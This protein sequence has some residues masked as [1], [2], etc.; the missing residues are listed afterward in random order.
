MK[1]FF[2]MEFTGLHQCTSPISLGLV[3]ESGEEF[4][5]EFTDY[6]RGQVDERVEENVIQHLYLGKDGYEYESKESSPFLPFSSCESHDLKL[7]GAR[8]LVM[9]RLRHWLA[10]FSSVEMWG[11][12]LAYD[13]VLFCELFGGELP[14]NVSYIPFDICTL[15]WV[16]GVD[17]DTERE[18]FSGMTGTKHNALHDARVIKACH[19]KLM[20]EEEKTTTTITVPWSEV[21]GMLRE[22]VANILRRMG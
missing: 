6:D 1:V 5:A 12:C 3:S 22:E 10:Q 14:R 9:N 16:K 17:P 21:R 18:K 2:D 20:G 8:V 15:F 11:D 7:S 19:E 4:Y 13:W